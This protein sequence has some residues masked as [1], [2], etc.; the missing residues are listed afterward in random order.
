MAPGMPYCSRIPRSQGRQD[1]LDTLAA[2]D[3][4]RIE[5]AL[6]GVVHR[7]D[8]GLPLLGDPREPAMAATVEVHQLAPARARLAAAPVAAARPM[9]RQQA[10][11]L[12][13]RLHVRVGQRPPVRAAR[14]LVEVPRVEAGV[15]FTIEP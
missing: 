2:L 3:Q 12:Q 13:S 10:G 15:L 7:D 9:L 5:H 4:L 14:D 1:G 11:L 6:G 8:Q